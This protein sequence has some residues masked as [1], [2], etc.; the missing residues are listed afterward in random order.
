M[1]AHAN[2]RCSIRH[3]PLLAQRGNKHDFGTVFT[4]AF[5]RELHSGICGD[6][7]TRVST[8]IEMQN[9]TSCLLRSVKHPLAEQTRIVAEVERRLSVVE[10]L[11]AMVSANLKCAKEGSFKGRHHSR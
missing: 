9:H 6:T 10:E 4:D 5:L 7:A 8:N 3:S 11:E 2:T 1:P